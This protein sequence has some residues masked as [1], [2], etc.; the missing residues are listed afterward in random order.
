MEQ[1]IVQSLG[2]G[3]GQLLRLTEIWPNAQLQASS[4]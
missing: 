1:G 3:L 2:C 4:L